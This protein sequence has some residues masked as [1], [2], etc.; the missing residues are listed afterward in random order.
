MGFF[1]HLWHFLAYKHLQKVNIFGL[2]TSLLLSTLNIHILWSVSYEK[3]KIKVLSLN[4]EVWTFLSGQC[5]DKI[6]ASLGPP[7]MFFIYLST[8]FAI[9]RR[10]QILG[11]V[12]WQGCGYF[13]WG[14]MK[15]SLARFLDDNKLVF[16][17]LYLKGSFKSLKNQV[18]FW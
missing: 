2:P 3:F 18:F 13:V 5:P 9:K 11:T 6:K 16:L 10:I 7:K 15:T 4:N 17:N 12:I 8:N 14:M 1:D